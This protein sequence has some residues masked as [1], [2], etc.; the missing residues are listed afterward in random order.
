[1]HKEKNMCVLLFSSLMPWGMV[2]VQ[3][4]E[5]EFYDKKWDICFEESKL[6][7]R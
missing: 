4:P 6:L 2:N 7:Q 5:K 3:S 1:M